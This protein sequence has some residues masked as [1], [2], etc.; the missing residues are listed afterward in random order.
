MLLPTSLYRKVIRDKPLDRDKVI[1][2]SEEAGVAPSVIAGRLL[3]DKQAPEDA[4]SGLLEEIDLTAISA[5]IPGQKPQGTLA[6]LFAGRTGGF[7]GGG[8]AWSEDT[9]KAFTEAMREKHG[10]QD[11]EAAR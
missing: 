8:K 10:Y 6:E 2:W 7:H 11:E 3:R 1:A 4:L 9:G 5:P